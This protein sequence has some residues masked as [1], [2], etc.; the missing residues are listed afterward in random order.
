MDGF[1]DF[2][3][4]NLELYSK[5]LKVALTE[6]GIGLAALA[7]AQGVR[8]H[9]DTFGIRLTESGRKYTVTAKVRIEGGK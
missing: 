2:D 9:S 4:K 5:H 7:E 8:L 6:Y 3:D 1:D